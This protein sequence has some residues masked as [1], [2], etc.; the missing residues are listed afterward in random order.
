MKAHSH[1]GAEQLTQMTLDELVLHCA[2]ETQHYLEKQASDTRYC[3]ELMRKALYEKS[4]EAFTQVYRTYEFLV[5]HWVYA[6][7]AF[8]LVEDSAD[9][10]VTLAFSNFYFAARGDKFNKFDSLAQLLTYLKRCVHTAIVQYLRDTQQPQHNALD[11][12]AIPAAHSPEHLLTLADIWQRISTLLPD[13]TDQLL[14]NCVFS[15]GLKP[16]DIIAVYP[17]WASTR[18]VSVNLQRIRRTLRKDAELQQLLGF[19]NS[20]RDA[21]SSVI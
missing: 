5:R 8:S 16:A 9:H 19:E 7:S 14:A 20:E 3:L 21:D 18:D 10:F 13:E 11:D 1:K 17:H 15:Q 4:S 6:H 2:E 12:E